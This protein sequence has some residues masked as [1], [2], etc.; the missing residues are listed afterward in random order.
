MTEA[1]REA[2]ATAV[3]PRF[4]RLGAS[5]IAEKSP[6]EPVTPADHEAEAI[7]AARLARLRPNARFVGEEATARDPALLASLGRGEVWIVDP[8]DGT[9]NYAAG[10]KPFAMMAA[11]LGD[12]E[13]L[14]AAIL[15][16][17]SGE[18]I[19]AERGR[20]AWSAGE[21]MGSVPTA[22]PLGA[23]TGIVS[24]FMRPPA[25]DDG[26]ARLRQSVREP[27]PTQRC[28][29]AEYPAVARGN[30]D[31]ALYWR[32]LVWDH[33]AGALIVEEAGGKVARL[34]GA[35]YRPADPGIGVLAARTPE[36]WDQVA[37]MLAA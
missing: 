37:A 26:I 5:E 28:A 15:D 14:A 2:A 11:L 21:R 9:A 33:A 30:R 1:L 16:P 10:H 20:G 32:T 17:V 3:M 34:D 8:I 27:V 35:P 31:F 25:L 24:D 7:I 23:C 18:A 12:G 22:R 4:R 29:G 13:I 19:S 6:G 36:A